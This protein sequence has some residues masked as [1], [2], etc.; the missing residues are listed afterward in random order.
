MTRRAVCLFE[1]RPVPSVL[2]AAE[3]IDAVL[4]AYF[5]FRTARG[6]RT[7]RGTARLPAAKTLAGL[8]CSVQPSVKGEQTEHSGKVTLLRPV[9]ERQF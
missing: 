6:L 4:G 5:E 2:A 3:G 7:A 9:G 1:R 8:E